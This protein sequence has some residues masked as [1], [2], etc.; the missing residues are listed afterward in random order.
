MLYNYYTGGRSTQELRAMLEYRRLNNGYYNNPY[1]KGSVST[2]E[3]FTTSTT[4]TTAAS[5]GTP[6]SAADAA[7]EKELAALQ[8]AGEEIETYG[9]DSIEEYQEFIGTNTCTDGEDDGKIGFWNAAGNILEGAVKSLINLPKTL[10]C[11][12]K[13]DLSLLKIGITAAAAV[14]CYFCSPLLIV[15]GIYGVI[16]GGSKIIENV[17]TALNAKTD[18]QAKAA[19]ENVGDGTLTVAGSALAVKSGVSGTASMVSK[20][21][22][23]ALKP[24]SSANGAANASGGIVNA[25]KNLASSFTNKFSAFKNNPLGTIGNALSSACNYIG[26]SIQSFPNELVSFAK[27]PIGY[28]GNILQGIKTNINLLFNNA[29][30]YTPPPSGAATSASRVIYNKVLSNSGQQALVGEAPLLLTEGINII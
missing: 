25:F 14:A 5:T 3:T 6:E 21:A 22:G 7:D 15:G 9:Y 27:N 24:V 1:L 19:W 2:T 20:L 16:S 11:D 10:L 8:A 13:G 12:E 4:A 17:S 29:R 28:I 23:T 30:P 26:K 18:A